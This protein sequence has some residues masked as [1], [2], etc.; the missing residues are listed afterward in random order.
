MKPYLIMIYHSAIYYLLK[1]AWFFNYKKRSRLKQFKDMHKGKRCFIIGNGPSLNIDD[2]D[3]L[4][5]EIT[6]SCNMIYNIYNKTIWKPYYYFVVDSKYLNEYYSEISQVVCKSKFIGYY[7]E[8]HNIVKEKYCEKDNQ[9]LYFIDK[10][11][12][13]KKTLKKFSR[14]PNINIY[15]SGSVSYSILQFAF[16]MGFSEIYL[17][18]F[19][20]K[21]A[22]QV[23]N[24]KIN[25][26]R[27]NNHFIGYNVDNINVVNHDNI[28][29]GF[30][31]A[32]I[33][34]KKKDI[35]IINATRGGDLEMFD[36]VNIE[37][38]L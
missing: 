38:I 1:L 15:N 17:I 28:N 21:F 3:K 33:Y 11:P 5:D 36:R 26:N 27:I 37:D 30:I 24:G 9:Y 2:L 14:A 22:N 20:H 34:A 13:L 8:T 35:K 29:Q 31:N 25:K 12:F 10:K 23:K 7:Y 18:G 6:F 4:K 19:D 16:Y 32:K